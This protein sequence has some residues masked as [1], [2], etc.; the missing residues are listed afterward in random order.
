MVILREATNQGI[1]KEQIFG[2]RVVEEGEGVV[3]GV[4]KGR[5]GYESGGEASG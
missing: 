3:R 2:V 5:G 1:E 4:E